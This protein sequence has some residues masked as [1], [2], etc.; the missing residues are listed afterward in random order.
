[1]A[2]KTI[3]DFREMKKLGEKITYVVAYDAHTAARAEEAGIE[4][5]LVFTAKKIL[6]QPQ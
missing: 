2:K 1:M 6:F 3:L 4:M 5:I